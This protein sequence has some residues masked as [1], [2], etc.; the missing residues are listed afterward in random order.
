MDPVMSRSRTTKTIAKRIDLGYFQRPHPFRT[1]RAFLSCAAALIPVVVWILYALAGKETAYN[2]GPVSELHAHFE[3]HCFKCHDATGHSGY[4]K[5]VSDSACLACHDASAHHPT[6]TLLISS[7]GTRAAD[8][9]ACHVE[10]RGRAVLAATSFNSLCTQ[11]HADLNSATMAGDSSGV[12]NTTTMFD[13]SHHPEF[14]RQLQSRTDPSI[15]KFD[16]KVHLNL[17][18]MKS[19]AAMQQCYGCHSTGPTS[20]LRS[21]LPAYI[22]PSRTARPALWDRSSEHRYMRPIQYEKH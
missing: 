3:Q 22:L 9:V 6:Q 21:S 20:P 7:D 14:A 17:A 12:A 1:T 5:A 13:P 2:P 10:H 11:C 8:C 15:I 18:E 4:S 16:H 19:A